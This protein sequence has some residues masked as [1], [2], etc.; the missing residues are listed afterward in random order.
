[1]KKIKNLLQNRFKDMFIMSCKV[2][3]IPK[4]NKNTLNS[5]RLAA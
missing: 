2:S 5:F 3:E 4:Q 1:M